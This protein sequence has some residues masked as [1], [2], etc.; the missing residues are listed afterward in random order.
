MLPPET[1]NGTV[2]LTAELCLARVQVDMGISLYLDRIDA[3]PHYLLS[4]SLLV[5][6]RTPICVP[7]P[8]SISISKWSGSAS[9]RSFDDIE[10][11]MLS[12]VR[13]SA[14]F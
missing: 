9:Q 13:P 5:I 8:S 12:I 3:S 4:H 2:G 6:R 10:H 14:V 1:L 11:L 7:Q